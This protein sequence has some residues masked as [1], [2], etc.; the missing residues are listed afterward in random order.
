MLV[1]C[2]SVCC[3]CGG[4][5]AGL[6]F[7]LS[8]VCLVSGW[9]V[10]W[11]PVYSCLD[12]TMPLLRLD[13]DRHRLDQ[14]CSMT[15]PLHR[16]GHTV[17]RLVSLSHKY[18]SVRGAQD[19]FP[20]NGS[21]C[22]DRQGRGE[23]RDKDR[24]SDRLAGVADGITGTNET[25]LQTRP[26]SLKVPL[27]TYPGSKTDDCLRSCPLRTGGGQEQCLAKPQRSTNQTQAF[28]HV[29]GCNGNIIAQQGEVVTCNNG[30][31]DMEIGGDDHVQ[32]DDELEHI[33]LGASRSL[34]MKTF[35]ILDCHLFYKHN[36]KSVP[37]ANIL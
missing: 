34:N 2:R 7:C 28:R 33:H 37:A 18:R 5:S 15:S 36:D 10:C 3:W 14:T 19:S 23:E 12:N 11:S 21:V 6:F 20:Q 25:F 8:A 13:P 1:V 29:A 16:S 27:Q 31:D 30:G 24:S 9:C 22:T 4:L 17:T 32:T 26:E 35:K